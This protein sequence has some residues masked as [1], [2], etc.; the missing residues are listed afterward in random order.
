MKSFPAPEDLHYITNLS[1]KLPKFEAKEDDNAF[2]DIHTKKAVLKV[3]SSVVALLSY[4]TGEQELFQSSGVIIEN[5]GNNGHI[6]LTSANLIRHPTEEDVV[7]D[8]LADSLKVSMVYVMS[9]DL[10]NLLQ[11][12]LNL[13]NRR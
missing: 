1:R 4:T 9:S 2:L 6:V 13:I 8:K 7:E 12:S 10:S 5:D 3:S 11:Y